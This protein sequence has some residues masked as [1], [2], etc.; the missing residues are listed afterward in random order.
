METERVTGSLGGARYQRQKHEVDWTETEVGSKEQIKAE[1]EQI[2]AERSRSRLRRSRSW[3]RWS[4][5]EQI[6]GR[7]SPERPRGSPQ[8]SVEQIGAEMVTGR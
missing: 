7:E 5:A 8:V 6:E 1:A 3:P 4:P 2:K